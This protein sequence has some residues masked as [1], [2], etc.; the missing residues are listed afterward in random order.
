[1]HSTPDVPRDASECVFCGLDFEGYVGGRWFVRDEARWAPRRGYA[2]TACIPWELREP[3]WEHMIK[4]VLLE[5]GALEA[6]MTRAERLLRTVAKLHQEW[7]RDARRR[8]AICTDVFAA[9]LQDDVVDPAHR[10]GQE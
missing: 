6:S 9:E 1:M 8:V 7:P 2:H 4:Q 5:L 10:T 3:P